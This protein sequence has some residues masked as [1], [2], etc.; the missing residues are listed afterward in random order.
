MPTI[1][2]IGGA[3]ATLEN[4]MQYKG[5]ISLPGDFPLLAEVETGWFFKILADV[6]DDDPTKTDTG[7]TFPASHEIV[8]NGTSWDDVGPPTQPQINQDTFIAT[9]LQTVFVLTKTYLTGGM[10][11]VTMNGVSYSKG[12][13]FTIAGTTLTWLDTD[14]TLGAGDTVITTYEF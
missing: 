3:L 7:Q 13:D 14:F 2:D 12:T 6:T 5:A 9:A 8:W 10:A 4:P 11:L 1:P